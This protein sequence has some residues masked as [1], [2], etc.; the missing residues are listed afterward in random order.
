MGWVRT[1]EVV[2]VL[3]QQLLGAEWWEDG[4]LHV[5]AGCA[6]G[7]DEW[8]VARVAQLS[9]HVGCEVAQAR[10]GQLGQIREV[11]VHG[12]NAEATALGV[13]RNIVVLEPVLGEKKRGCVWGEWHQQEEG[14]GV[15]EY[16]E[17][18]GQRPWQCPPAWR[19]WPG[20]CRP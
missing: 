15:T 20:L 5:G 11:F 8:H 14:V 19:R 18:G 13:G 9:Q 6:E 2:R 7:L 4:L 10:V 3:E 12:K 1:W 16:F 17:D